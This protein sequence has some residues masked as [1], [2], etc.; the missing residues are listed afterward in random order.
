MPNSQT[1]V[2]YFS[3]IITPYILTYIFHVT[4]HLR[5]HLSV[6]LEQITIYLMEFARLINYTE[7]MYIKYRAKLEHS[8]SK[9]HE[10]FNIIAYKDFLVNILK[11]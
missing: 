7:D 11:D 8:F 9:R 3:F 2:V 10:I 5:P 4:V 1:L 6:R